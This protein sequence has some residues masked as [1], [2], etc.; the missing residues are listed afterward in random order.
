[1]TDDHV[2]PRCFFQKTCPNDAERITVPCCETCRQ[3]DEKYDSFT[4]NIIAGLL[5]TEST[6][7]VQD[8]IADRVSR[9]VERA[10]WEARRLTEVMHLKK[11]S[12]LTPSGIKD[13][14]LPALNLDIPEMD[15]FFERIAR[16]VLY[17]AHDMEFF[18]GRVRWLPIA[19]IPENLAQLCEKGSTRRTVLD[20][21]EYCVSP[22]FDAGTYIALV[23]FYK[24][25]TFLLQVETI[26][27]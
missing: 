5:E 27:T 26:Q 24:A 10:R 7:Y 19:Q 15:R 25:Q 14:R 1:M 17:D 2:P 4:R 3:E 20:V 8:H 16:A 18:A 23:T 13:G 21:F 12:V 9:S 6:Q 11:V 22:P